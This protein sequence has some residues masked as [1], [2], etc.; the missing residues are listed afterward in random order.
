[1][2]NQIFHGGATFATGW[3]PA[4]VRD[5]S[6]IMASLVPVIV[7]IMEADIESNPDSGTWGKVAY[8]RINESPE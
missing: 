8:P 5:G 2:R 4:Q 6:R 3:G 1:M 7:D